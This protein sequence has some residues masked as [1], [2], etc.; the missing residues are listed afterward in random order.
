MLG[1]RRSFI[2]TGQYTNATGLNLQGGHEV[3]SEG[4]FDGVARS[5]DIGINC[6]YHKK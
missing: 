5:I 1:T 2:T 4:G 6:V 3:E